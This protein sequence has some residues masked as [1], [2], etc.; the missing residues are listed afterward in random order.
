ML[1]MI[2]VA[3]FGGQGVLRIGQMICYAGLDEGLEV[4]W[5]PSYGSA[6]RGGTANCSV[7]VSDEPVATPVIAPGDMTALI[8]M[9]QPSL[10]AFEG[11]LMEGGTVL[12]NSSLVHGEPKRSDLKVYKIPAN[13]M[14]I[15]AGNKLG[16]N[17]VVLGAFVAINDLV[18]IESLCKIVDD[19]FTGKKARFAE[20]NKQLL[21]AG[22]DY[23]KAHL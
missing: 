11:Q 10:D 17:M 4:S 3:G 21:H 16:A 12:L 8:V 19:T 15:E 20:S 2:K 1:E 18:S 14:A 13:E 22:Y 7:V 5:Y 6:M 23:M 9:N